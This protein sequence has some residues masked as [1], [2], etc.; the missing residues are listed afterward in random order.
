MLWI[1]RRV[2]L[3]QMA[4]FAGRRQCCVLSA[5][6]ALLTR[7]SYVS[8]SQR[9][10]KLRVIERCARPIRR[11]VAR[12]AGCRERPGNVIRH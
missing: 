12:F 2:K 7:Y 1:R 9:E 10:L 8:T 4:R 11:A 5:R 3:W 6:M